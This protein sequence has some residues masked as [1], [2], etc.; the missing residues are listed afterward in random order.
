MVIGI[1]G[2]E[3]KKFTEATER[4]AREAIRALLRENKPTLVVSGDCPLGGIDKWAIEEATK[5]GFA[6]R[7]FPPEV[8]SWEPISPG[9]IGFKR[10][11]EQIAEASDLVVCVVVKALPQT[12]SGR[13]FQFC[14][15]C[16]TDTHV[17]SGGCWTRK[18]AESIDKRGQT[19][20]ISDS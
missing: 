18:Y 10:R 7:E 2:H 4:K 3:A 12:Y 1:V 9:A 11:N 16:L 8:H 5:L 15:H 17:K 19:I 6:T 13:R 20:E 14:Y